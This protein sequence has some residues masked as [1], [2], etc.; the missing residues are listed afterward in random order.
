MKAKI[1]FIAIIVVII[2]G[3]FVA[4]C[5]KRDAMNKVLIGEIQN[6]RNQTYKFEVEL[7]RQTSGVWELVFSSVGTKDGGSSSRLSIRIK[8]RKL[9]KLHVAFGANA[10]R[11]N[12]GEEQAVFNGTLQELEVGRQI[13]TPVESMDAKYELIINLEGP[14]PSGAKFKV[15]AYLREPSL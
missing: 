12:S 9:S 15:F 3:I 13:V 11:L 8:N 2:G 1:I 10:I 7:P 4:K 14:L 6:D 5:G